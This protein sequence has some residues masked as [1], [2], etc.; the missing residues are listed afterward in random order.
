MDHNLSYKLA[1][2]FNDV[3]FNF[4]SVRAE[5]PGRST[6]P[7]EEII[8]WLSD[9]KDFKAIWVTA[10]DDAQKTHAKLIMARQISVLW[11]FRARRGLSALEELQLLSMVMQ[12]ATE[13]IFSASRSV[14]LKASFNGKRPKL[15]Q[16]SNTLHDKRL[17]WKNVNLRD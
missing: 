4:S 1:Q 12:K 8:G 3:G 2:A 13:I 11:I 9:Q 16:L 15:E 5:F 14:Y 17:N 7:D 6:V 10:D